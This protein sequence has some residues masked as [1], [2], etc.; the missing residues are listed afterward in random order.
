VVRERIEAQ[1]AHFD[2]RMFALPTIDEAYNNIYWR[3]AYDCHRNSVHGLAMCHFSNKQLHGKNR[4][5]T[6]TIVAQHRFS[7][8]LFLR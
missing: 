1:E 5:V 7:F 4:N 2:A 6:Q 8:V 3:Q